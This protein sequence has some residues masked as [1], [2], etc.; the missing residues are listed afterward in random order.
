MKDIKFIQCAPDDDY[1]LWQVRLWL[2]S[3]R[4]RNLSDKAVSLI[5]TPKSREFNKK[6]LDIEKEYSES[7]FKFYKDEQGKL[8][9]LIRIYIPI[10]RPYCLAKYFK[11]TADIENKV[12]FYCDSDILFTENFNI[13]KYIDDD[14]CYLSDT[15]SYIGGDYLESKINQVLPEKLEE[16]KKRD[17]I[18]EM[19]SFLKITKEVVK[20]NQ[21][22]SGGAQYL[23]KNVDYKFWEKVLEDCIKIRVYLQQVNK[24]FFENESKGFQS[25]AS[26]MWAVLWNLWYLEKETK[27]IPEMEF[28]WSTSPI[29]KLSEVGIMHNAGIV[30]EKHGDI[31]VFYKGKYHQG[32]NPLEDPYLEEIFNNEKTKTLCNWYYIS[33]LIQL[34]NN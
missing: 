34:K 14:I 15:I 5:F 19:A 1:Y 12:I 11:E 32:K 26:D 16:Y 23:L 3:L 2:N 13:D 33:K 28:A 18:E 24:E 9:P 7:E 21:N 31:P 27:V 8:S 22:S 29:S 6:W 4:E 25:W 10:I 20:A 17:I 30:S